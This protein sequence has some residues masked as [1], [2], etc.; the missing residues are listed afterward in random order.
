M[1]PLFI[2][3]FI[4]SHEGISFQNTATLFKEKRSQDANILRHRLISHANVSLQGQRAQS[5]FSAGYPE[6][7]DRMQISLVN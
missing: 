6:T 4:A 2:C 3:V 1:V 7:S 5:F